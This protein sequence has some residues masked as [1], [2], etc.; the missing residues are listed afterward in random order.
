MIDS[1]E[2][3][4]LGWPGRPRLRFGNHLALTFYWFPNNVLWTGLLLIVMPAKVISLVGSGAATGSLSILELVG[5]FVAVLAAPIFGAISDRWRSRIGRRR[6]QM[7]VGVIGNVV[8]LLIMAF[9]ANFAILLVGFIGVQL[10]NN[11][12]GSAYNGLIPDLV[13][14][15]QRGVASGF[16]GIWNNAAVLVGA[17]LAAALA[18][19]GYWYATSFL[20]LLGVAVT[21]AFVREPAPPDSRRFNLGVFLRGFLIGGPEYRDFWWVYITRFLVMM[22]IYILEYYLSYYLQFVLHVAHPGTDVEYLLFLLTGTAL[23]S[24]LTAGYISDRIKRRKIMVTAAGIL[25]GACALLFVVLNSLTAVFIAAAIFGL[26]Y[27][28]YMSTDYAL[29][30]DTLPG[31]TAAKDMGIWGTSQTLPQVLVSLIGLSV[32]S[33]VIPHL[34]ASTGYRLLFAVTFVLFLLGSILVWRVKKVA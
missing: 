30:V 8:F 3:P 9:A 12:T 16:M 13:P 28:T 25:M 5:A 21:L 6:P 10:F 4:Y 17:V 33:L 7:V 19:M 24:A 14:A 1:S 2:S 32:A 34:G 15:E 31:Q 26:G 23:L 20:L 22:G 29:V 11:V 18:G 27:G